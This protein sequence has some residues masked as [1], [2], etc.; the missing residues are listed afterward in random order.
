MGDRYNQLLDSLHS[1][2]IG[3]REFLASASALGLAAGLPKAARAQPK[4]G[5]RLRIGMGHGSTTDTLDPA[6]FENGYM[7]QL[8]YTI[9]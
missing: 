3:R 7:L 8:T 4:Q 2:R 6:T 9:H 5:G 1:G